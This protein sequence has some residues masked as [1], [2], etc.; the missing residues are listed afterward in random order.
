VHQPA[1]AHVDQGKRN[2]KQ[3]EQQTAHCDSNGASVHSVVKEGNNSVCSCSNKVQHPEHNRR[4]Q[5]K[6]ILDP[7]RLGVHMQPAILGP[8]FQ[9]ILNA[10]RR[11]VEDRH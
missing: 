5:C 4:L 8:P 6:G 10:V 1:H 7:A 3:V 11:K 9:R 2:I